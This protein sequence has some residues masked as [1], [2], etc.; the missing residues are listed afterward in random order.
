M[1]YRFM[2]GQGVVPESCCNTSTVTTK[3]E[4]AAIHRNVTEADVSRYYKIYNQVCMCS[5]SHA[6]LFVACSAI[7]RGGPGIFPHVNMM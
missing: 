5:K 7:K 4:C 1:D 6:Q 3:E 2:L